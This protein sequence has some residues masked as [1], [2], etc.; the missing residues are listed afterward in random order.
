MAF[1]ILLLIKKYYI[2]LNKV[3]TSLS[4]K[5]ALPSEIEISHHRLNKNIQSTFAKL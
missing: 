3:L 1:L 2:N 5:S 4:N